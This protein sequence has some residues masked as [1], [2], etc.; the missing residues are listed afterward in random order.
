[1]SQ[2]Y[3]PDLFF[4][5]LALILLAE[6]YYPHAS[7]KRDTSGTL[8]V[9]PSD[10]SVPDVRWSSITNPDD[11]S[12][13]PDTVNPIK[14]T[15]RVGEILYLPVGW[16][17]YVRQSGLTIAVNWWYDAELRGMT[18][19]LLNVLRN[20]LHIPLANESVYMLE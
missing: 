5:Q 4:C 13:L 8:R 9:T 12:T 19:V 16:W 3:F 11:P 20:Q 6:R 15:L 18:W 1:M 17:H 7:Y 10:A 14:I 2:R